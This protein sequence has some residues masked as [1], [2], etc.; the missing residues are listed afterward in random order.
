MLSNLRAA[1]AIAETRY[2]A[3]RRR[4]A[5]VRTFDLITDPPPADP[6][7]K[8]SRGRVAGFR[9][10]SK[11]RAKTRRRKKRPIPTTEAG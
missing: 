5:T 11:G 9:T 4:N 3:E 10:M 6:A 1:Q 8:T 7:H 2:D